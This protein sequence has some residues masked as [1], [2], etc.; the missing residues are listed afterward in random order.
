MNRAFSPFVKSL[1]VAMLAVSGAASASAPA[2]A[3]KAD[4]AKGATLYAEGDNARGI[5]ACVSCHGAKGASTITINPKLGG[6]GEAYI[7]KQL[8]AFTEPS[9][10]GTVMTAFAKALTDEEK[11]NIA[12]YLATEP[13]KAGAAKNK[14]TIELGKKIYRGGIAENRVPA[15]ASCHGPAGAGMPAAYPR[16]GGQHQD[17]TVATLKAFK[18]DTRK[19]SAEMHAIAYRMSDKEIEAVADYMAGLK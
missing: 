14:D 15:C 5:A 9:R 7:Y 10:A 1:F 2:P 3:A 13:N 11:K 19:T 18:A 16:V 17:Y 8:V 12:A 4:P 6:Q